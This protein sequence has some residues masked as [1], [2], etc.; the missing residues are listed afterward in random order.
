SD[1][2]EILCK[3]IEAADDF[4][5][6]VF[7]QTKSLVTDLTNYLISRKY[8]VDS[9]HGDKSQHERERTMQ[10]FRDKKVKVLICTDVASRG[11]DVKD[12]THV[13]NYSIPR[14]MDV[15][16][17]RIGRTARSGKSGV[18]VSL[19]TASHRPLIARIEQ[20]TKT[21]IKEGRIPSR[22][23]IGAKKIGKMLDPFL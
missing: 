11:L 7:C 15:Y 6:L 17:H 16:I 2:P 9:L 22:R 20:L 1:K 5:G 23:E 13:I 12:I 8:Q 3:I 21:R 14:E 4:Y 10:A 18:A 19:V